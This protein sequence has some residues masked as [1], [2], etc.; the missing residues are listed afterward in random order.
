MELVSLVDAGRLRTGLANGMRFDR[1]TSVIVVCKNSSPTVRF[2]D[3]IRKSANIRKTTLI[4]T[5]DQQHGRLRSNECKQV[6]RFIVHEWAGEALVLV[7]DKDN[8]YMQVVHM[9]VRDSIAGRLGAVT[10]EFMG[11]HSADPHTMQVTLRIYKDI[12]S[13]IQGNSSTELILAGKWGQPW[14]ILRT[15]PKVDV[16]YVSEAEYLTYLSKPH[17]TRSVALLLSAHPAEAHSP[18]FQAGLGGVQAQEGQMLDG[19]GKLNSRAIRLTAGIITSQPSASG[20]SKLILVGCT[21]FPEHSYLVDIIKQLQHAGPNSQPPRYTGIPALE[22]Q[23]LT[24]AI[25]GNLRS[26]RI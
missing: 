11:K 8:P 10:A 9:A 7:D 3:S 23:E 20:T 1:P 2:N 22:C 14:P 19:Q 12:V 4:Y 6:A 24:A 21:G 16:K 26:Q 13:E 15:L 17:K 5:T 25:I 18:K